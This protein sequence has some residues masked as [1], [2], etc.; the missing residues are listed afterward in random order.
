MQMRAIDRAIEAVGG[1]N[2]LAR[3]CGVSRQLIQHWRKNGVR[4]EHWKTIET[5][6]GGKIKAADFFRELA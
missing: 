5:A 6:T 2:S 4:V 1:V 3:L